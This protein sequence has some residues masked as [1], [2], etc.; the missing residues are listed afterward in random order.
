MQILRKLQRFVGR[1]LC[2]WDDGMK[3]SNGVG[4]GRCS[5]LRNQR[6]G[7]WILKLAWVSCGREACM[8]DHFFPVTFV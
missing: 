6:S 4:Y 8:L 3:T 2:G 1:K 7:D 5:D